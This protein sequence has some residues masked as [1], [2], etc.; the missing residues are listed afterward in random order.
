MVSGAAAILL[1]AALAAPAVQAGDHGDLNL[2]ISTDDDQP[3]E[4]CDQVRVEFGGRRHSLPSARAEKSFTLKKSATPVLEMH[5][6]GPGGMALR[7]GEGPDYAV[8]ACLAAAGATDEEARAA[9]ETIDVGFDGGRLSVSG[10]GVNGRLVYFLVQVPK[11]AV[12]DLRSDNG[13]IDLRGISGR[14]TARTH[15]GPLALDDCDGE[16]DVAAENGPLSL[17]AGAGHQRVSVTNGPLDIE[18]E[19]SRWEGE[20]IEAAAENGPVSLKIPE[21]YESGVSLRMS[22]NGPVSC[23]AGC[24][25]AWQPGSGAHSLLFGPAHPVIRIRSGNG[26]VSID[27]GIAARQSRSI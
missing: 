18:L 16:I 25:A 8:T 9:L 26:P 3:I 17:R 23:S 13:A 19:G 21:R 2:S 1:A 27:S 15:N 20:G 24:E 4:R 14:I 12:L 10:A 7:G 5:L 11:D 6:D 22:G